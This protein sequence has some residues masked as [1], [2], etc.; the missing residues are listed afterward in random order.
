MFDEV[1]QSWPWY[2]E[3][4]DVWPNFLSLQVKQGLIISNKHGIN[5]LP[6]ELPNDLRLKML[7]K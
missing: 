7:W 5:E 3:T 6:C 2:F 1:P 4:S